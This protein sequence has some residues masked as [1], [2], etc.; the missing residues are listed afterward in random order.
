MVNTSVS[1]VISSTFYMATAR[2]RLLEVN[3]PGVD[4]SCVDGMFRHEALLYAGIDEFLAGTVPFVAD[5]VAAGEPVL[6]VV[7]ADKIERI[8]AE[9]N[10]DAAAVHFADMAAV[11]HNPARIIPAWRQ[12]L[13]DNGGGR[14]PVRGIGEPSWSGRSE[15]ELVEC[16][17]DEALLNYAFDGSGG[18]QLLCPYDTSALAADVIAG[19]CGTHPHVVADGSQQ[20]SDTYRDDAAEPFDRRLPSPPSLAKTF[21]FDATTLEPARRFV[22]GYAAG[23][24]LL[25]GRRDDLAVA[26]MELMTN[27]VRHGGGQGVLQ[28]WHDGDRMACQVTDNGWL[29]DPLAGRVRPSTELERGR[30]LWLVNHLCDLVQIRSSPAGTVIRAWLQ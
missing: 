28:V 29:A 8:R 30:G 11:G 24:G 25:V 27:S 17:R 5:G 13:D 20:T 14:R 21:A 2:R 19:A 26:V 16:Q 12:F 15:D 9:L 18:W 23:H 3:V 6:V 4:A 7:S 10:G 22:A 1:P